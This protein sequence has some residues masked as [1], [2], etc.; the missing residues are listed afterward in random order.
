MRK[1]ECEK[2]SGEGRRTRREKGKKKSVAV[3]YIWKDD[4]AIPFISILRYSFI[5]FS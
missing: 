4:C 3:F 5:F 1:A 2:L